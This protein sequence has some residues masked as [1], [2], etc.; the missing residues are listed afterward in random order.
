MCPSLP[1]GWRHGLRIVVIADQHGHLPDIPECDLLLIAGDICN[2]LAGEN[3]NL[4]Y[5][6]EEFGPWLRSQPTRRV[7]AVAGCASFAITSRSL[8]SWWCSWAL[9]EGENDSPQQ[10]EAIANAV[11][12]AGLRCDFNLVRYNPFSAD[13]GRESSQEVI[14]RCAAQLAELVPKARVQVVGRVGYDVKASCGMFIAGHGAKRIHKT[15]ELPVLASTDSKFVGF[16][17]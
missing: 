9:I 16:G 14:D 8:A 1:A 5:L 7:V 3:E 17:A 4:A 6:A 2:G 10:I 12:E 15:Q 11:C 13:Q